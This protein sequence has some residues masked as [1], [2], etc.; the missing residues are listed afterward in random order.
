MNMDAGEILQFW[1]G[2]AC[3][4]PAETKARQ[5]F[6]F[7]GSAAVD[8][9]IR[10]R[11]LPLVARAL[12][13]ELA[14]WAAAPGTALALTL[15]LD[16]FPRNAWRGTARAF[17]GDSLALAT[18]RDALAAG[19]LDRLEPVQRVFLLLPLEHSESPADQ[20]ECVRHFTALAAS[21]PA[22]WQP[23]FD[24]YLA[25]ARQ[26]LEII[27]R[28]GRFPHRNRALGRISTAEERAWIDGGGAAFGQGGEE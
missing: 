3:A 1:F 15:L 7:G 11:F 21:V 2:D 13:G 9:A 17:A 10:D 26:H 14:A 4:G 24:G 5:G 25:Y 22:S 19:F 8:D 23:L 20:R 6:W 27:E 16:Q 18:T 12:R 28:F